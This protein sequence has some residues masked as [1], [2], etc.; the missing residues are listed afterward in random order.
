MA[1]MSHDL[2][3]PAHVEILRQK[4]FLRERI[5]PNQSDYYY[6]HL[7][8]LLEAMRAESSIEPLRI[9]DFGAGGSPY[10]SLFPCAQYQTADLAGSGAD[11][12]IQEDSSTNAPDQVFDLVLSTQVLEHCRRPER[13]LAEASRVLKPSGRLVLSTHGLFEDH[14]CPYDFFRWTADGLRSVLEEGGFQVRSVA[15]VTAGPRAAFHLL[16]SALSQSLLDRQSLPLRLIGRSLFRLLLARRFW[17]AFLDRAFADYR[18]VTSGDLPFS[19]TYVTLLAVA[20]RGSESNTP[21]KSAK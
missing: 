11:F 4:A 14:A 8:D 15:R 3:T 5:E 1:E 19:N 13:Y 18:V 2:A 10:R 21:I 16:Q 9:L 17:N 7:S 12:V 20:L 6:L